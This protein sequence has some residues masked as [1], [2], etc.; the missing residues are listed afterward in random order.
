MGHPGS[1][2]STYLSL[3]NARLMSRP[4]KKLIRDTMDDAATETD[5]IIE[6]LFE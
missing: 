3:L 2:E 6:P 1:D 4:M 5:E